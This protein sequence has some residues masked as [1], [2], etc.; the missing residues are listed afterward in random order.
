MKPK[1]DPIKQQPLYR[2]RA[3]PLNVILLALM[4]GACGIVALCHQI[5]QGGW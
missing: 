5:V 3:L 1:P 4:A 2:R